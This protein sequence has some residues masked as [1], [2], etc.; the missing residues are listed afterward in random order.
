MPLPAEKGLKPLRFRLCSHRNWDLMPLPA[1]K[2]LKPAQKRDNSGLWQRFDAPSSRKRIETLSLLLF[3]SFF[4]DLMP[5]PAEKGLKLFTMGVI[6]FRYM[7]DLMP[8]PAEK[9][10][11]H[12]FRNLWYFRRAI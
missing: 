3:L 11:K 5:L 2:G 12:R 9:G 7:Q 10:L 6:S 4:L 1:E 8:L